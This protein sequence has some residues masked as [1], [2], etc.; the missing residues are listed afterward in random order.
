MTER[1]TE[2]ERNLDPEPQNYCGLVFCRVLQHAT[3]NVRYLSLDH[4][5]ILCRFLRRQIPHALHLRLSS[6][7]VNFHRFTLFL[8]IGN[9]KNKDGKR[10]ESKFKL[11]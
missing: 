2:T 9:L 6:S 10:Y 5:V 11:F 4:L 3:V 7:N 1:E 8:V